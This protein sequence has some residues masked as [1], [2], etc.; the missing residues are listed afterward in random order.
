MSSSKAFNTIME[1]FEARG[2]IT[3]EYDEEHIVGY[4]DLG[5]LVCSFIP[6]FPTKF[7]VDQFQSIMN[8]MKQMELK[9]CIVVYANSIT[10]SARKMVEI[11]AD[12]HIELFDVND[13]QYNPTKHLW[14]PKHK[15]YAR[16]GSKKANDFITK[17][18]N[19]FPIILSSDPISRFY[20]FKTGDIIEIV[21]HNEMVIYRITK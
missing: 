4:T 9:Y 18:S 3:I 21:R 1:L 11:S 2:Y 16:K 7:N 17:Y 10:A 8:L 12:I 20:G 14:V 19:N 5:E 15:L 13:L 6:K